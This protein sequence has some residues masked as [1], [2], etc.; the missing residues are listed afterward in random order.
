MAFDNT[1]K[2]DEITNQMKQEGR[3]GEEIDHAIKLAHINEK[4]Q[5][6]KENLGFMDY[7]HGLEWFT[8]EEKDRFYRHVQENGYNPD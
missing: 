7:F 8:P 1:S 6:W 3:S 4:K 5:Y 2:V